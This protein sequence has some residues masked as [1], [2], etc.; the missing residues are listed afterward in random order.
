[1]SK[2]VKLA[3]DNDPADLDLRRRFFLASL[4]DDL[5]ADVEGKIRELKWHEHLGSLS[6]EMYLGKRVL[7]WEAGLGG[8]SA[9]FYCLGAAE[10]VAIDSWVSPGA[11]NPLI[12][13][14]GSFSFKNISIAD[15]LMQ[16]YSHLAS[17]DLVFSNTVTEHIGDLPSALLNIKSLL[18]DDGT[19]L[20]IHDNY[21]SPCGSHDHGFWFYDGSGAIAFQGVACWTMPEKCDA[22][23]GHRQG[24]LDRMPWTWN[25][26]LEQRRDPTACAD[27]PYYR[28]GQ[29]WAHLASVDK[30]VETFD[31]PSFLTWQPGS[32]LNK[33]TTFQM[34]QLLIEAGFKVLAFHRNRCT[35]L[36]SD[37]LIDAGFSQ[38][39]LT[40]TTTVWTCSKA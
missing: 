4:P 30:F 17:F 22:S 7:D 3:G 16:D 40:T 19:Y 9:A 24:L 29:P 12:H 14:I 34:R 13:S 8:F 10:V 31:D 38:L 39:E 26:R 1:V 20:N 28:R 32:S 35:N 6:P 36:P 2:D 21:Y 27:C 37:A 25:E 23:A 15:F 18:K 11:I 33:V 5:R